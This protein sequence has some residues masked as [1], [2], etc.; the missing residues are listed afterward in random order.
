ML[1]LFS[2]AEKKLKHINGKHRPEPSSRDIINSLTCFRSDQMQRFMDMDQCFSTSATSL[3]DQT[4]TSSLG[5]ASYIQRRL[6]PERQAIDME[7]LFELLKDDELAKNRA[8]EDDKE[9]RYYC[10]SEIQSEHTYSA[11]EL[12]KD[13]QNIFVEV[14]GSC[15]ETISTCAAVREVDSNEGER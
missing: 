14:G 3:T 15:E 2:F 8:E 6:H 1:Y 7:E 9:G 10:G 4:A 5:S 11:E 13:P 12:K